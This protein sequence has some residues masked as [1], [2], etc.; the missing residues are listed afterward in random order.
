M[1]DSIETEQTDV[2]TLLAGLASRLRNDGVA[3][4]GI[5]C[6]DT[7]PGAVEHR[8]LTGLA[9]SLERTA[10]LL[11]AVKERLCPEC[12]LRDVVERVTFGNVPEVVQE[13]KTKGE[14]D[15]E[16]EEDEGRQGGR[17]RKG[18]RR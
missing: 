3:L 10:A 9:H 6:R 11:E 4:A 2:A 12:R 18:R 1:H 17:Q 5:A 13:S 8:D 7:E 14:R 16:Q 15:H